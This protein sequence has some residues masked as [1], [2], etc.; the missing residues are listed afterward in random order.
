M[1][2]LFLCTENRCFLHKYMYMKRDV[3][4]DYDQPTRPPSY[5]R[6]AKLPED[7]ISDVVRA[8]IKDKAFNNHLEKV[9]LKVIEKWAKKATKK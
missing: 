4:E 8:L 5:R 7:D 6:K 9:M 2:A 3:Y 1:V